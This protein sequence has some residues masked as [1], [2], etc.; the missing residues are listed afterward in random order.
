MTFQKSYAVKNKNLKQHNKHKERYQKNLFPCKVCGGTTDIHK[1][2]NKITTVNKITG[3][4]NL[5][6]IRENERKEF[7][8]GGHGREWF[9]NQIRK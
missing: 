5:C 1:D 4:C 2:E 3:L 8:K 9:V 7:S 6:K